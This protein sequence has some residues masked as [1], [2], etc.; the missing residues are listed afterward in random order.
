MAIPDTNTFSLQDVVNEIV[1]TTN[2]LIDCFA[3]AVPGNFD[4][5]YS[6][7]TNELLNFRNYGAASS[8]IYYYNRGV[9]TGNWAIAYSGGSG[10]VTFTIE[11][12]YLSLIKTD[13]AFCYLTIRTDEP[14]NST[15]INNQKKLNVILSVI[16]FSGSTYEFKFTSV[17]AD[18]TGYATTGMVDLTGVLVPSG[19]VLYTA[20]SP[21]TT[22][23]PY[24][25]FRLNTNT[26]P[27]TTYEIRIHEIYYE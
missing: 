20:P 22:S 21:P 11:A 17:S 16:S 19:E 3:D 15:D 7:N 1:P 9:S 18:G 23:S 6:G 8:R 5:T 26:V 2:D 10:I 14:F 12:N 27:A 4:P 25:G 13:P 24:S